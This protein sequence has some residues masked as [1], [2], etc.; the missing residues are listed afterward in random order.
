MWRTCILCLGIIAL[1]S[2]LHQLYDISAMKDCDIK[3]RRTPKLADGCHHVFIDAGSNIGLN[4]RMLFEPHLYPEINNTKLGKKNIIT[5]RKFFVSQFGPEETRNNDDICIFAFEPNPLHVSKHEE[6][7]KAYNSMGWRYHFIHAGVSD[8]EGMLTFYH[9]GK[10][11]KALERGFTMV[12]SKCHNECRPE[13][14]TVVRLS[15][16][17]KS[18][19]HGRV[20]PAVEEKEPQPRVVMKMDIEMGEWLVVPD[21]IASGVLCQDIDALAG[22]YHLKARKSS[23]P[24]HVPNRNWTLR[25]Y[26]E[27]EALKDEMFHIIE[28]NPHCKTEL[29]EVDDESYEKDEMPWP[30]KRKM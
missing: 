20:I 28:R 6:M 1:T 17:I 10:G 23:Y 3:R 2:R 8:D 9:I 26:Q 7:Q 15:E 22:E 12:K 25:T 4:S 24:M 18:E 19:I 21:L 27:A 16:W 13:N 29:V 11:P 5:P 30:T 14:V